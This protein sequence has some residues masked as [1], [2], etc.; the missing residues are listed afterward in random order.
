MMLIIRDPAGVKGHS[1]SFR[2]RKP[3]RSW[4]LKWRLFFLFMAT[5]S[6]NKRLELWRLEKTNLF[7][8]PTFSRCD[9]V[10][11]PLCLSAVWKCNSPGREAASGGRRRSRASPASSPPPKFHLCPSAA[12]CGCDHRSTCLSVLQPCRHPQ[13]PGRRTHDAPH[14]RRTKRRVA[15]QDG[16]GGD[17]CWVR[18]RRC[19]RHAGGLRS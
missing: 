7:F 9:K 11:K 14:D 16:D 8:S 12:G 13:Q 2:N 18:V 3:L 6:P 15:G 17:T 19:W 4:S 10:V 1:Y 5:K